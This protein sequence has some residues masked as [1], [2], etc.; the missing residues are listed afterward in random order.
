MCCG[1][2][3]PTKDP[4]VVCEVCLN[5]LRSSESTITEDGKP[6]HYDCWM[7][8]QHAYTYDEVHAY[9]KERLEDLSN[10]QLAP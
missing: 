9:W 3:A 10:R 7:A 2:D 6:Y 1:N 5:A 8:F 4:L